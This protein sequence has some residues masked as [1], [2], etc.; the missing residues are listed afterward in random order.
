MQGI[1][2]THQEFGYSDGQGGSRA[3]E[4]FAAPS[5]DASG[6]GQGKM[7]AGWE[8]LVL[9]GWHG[10]RLAAASGLQHGALAG[11]P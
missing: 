10:G 8:W 9:S 7:W 1:R 2:T 6:K 5:L 11:C 4:V 3:D